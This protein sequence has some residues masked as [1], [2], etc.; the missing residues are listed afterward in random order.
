MRSWPVTWQNSGRLWSHVLKRMCL[1]LLL[2]FS[3]YPNVLLTVAFIGA[4]RWLL[5]LTSLSS[6][7]FEAWMLVLLKR[8]W[9]K[10]KSWCCALNC[11]LAM[12]VYILVRLR[13]F[14]QVLAQFFLLLVLHVL[15]RAIEWLTCDA[16]L[17]RRVPSIG[18]DCGVLNWGFLQVVA[19]WGA[20]ELLPISVTFIVLVTFLFV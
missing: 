10:P 14:S 1:K 2:N 19:A 5:E 8:S 12:K 6:F 3:S 7:L 18:L 16:S 20:H 17:L 11:F 9:F 4:A 13:I 15:S